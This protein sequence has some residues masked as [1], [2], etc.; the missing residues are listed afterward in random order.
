LAKF[1]SL[2][3]PETPTLAKFIENA[4]RITHIDLTD[5]KMT[6]SEAELLYFSMDPSR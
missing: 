2:Y 4:T 5:R 6:K 1:K 3:K